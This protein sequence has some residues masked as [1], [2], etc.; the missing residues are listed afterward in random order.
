MSTNDIHIL[1]I[2]WGVEYSVKEAKEKLKTGMSDPRKMGENWSVTIQ[3]CGRPIATY[4]PDKTNDR[5][6]MLCQIMQW[7]ETDSSAFSDILSD[8]VLVDNRVKVDRPLEISSCNFNRKKSKTTSLIGWVVPSISSLHNKN[9]TGTKTYKN[10]R[11]NRQIKSKNKKGI[12]DNKLVKISAHFG[13][14]HDERIEKAAAKQNGCLNIMETEAMHK[15]IQK[16]RFKP[17]KPPRYVTDNVPTSEWEIKREKI[18]DATSYA[19]RHGLYDMEIRKRSE[20][21]ERWQQL[22]T[23]YK[24]Q[25]VNTRYHGGGFFL[26]GPYIGPTLLH[27]GDGRFYNGYYTIE[28][29]DWYSTN[30][31]P[32]KLMKI[33]Y[34]PYRVVTTYFGKEFPHWADFW[35]WYWDETPGPLSLTGLSGR[36]ILNHDPRD[37]DSQG[38]TLS[39]WT[40]A[41][42]R[43]CPTPW[44]TPSISSASSFDEAVSNSV[45]GSSTDV[46]AQ[47][48]VDSS[49][50]EYDECDDDCSSEPLCDDEYDECDDDCSS[51]PLCVDDNLPSMSNKS[52]KWPKSGEESSYDNDDL[53]F[54]SRKRGRINR[55]IIDDDSSDGTEI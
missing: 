29:R 45:C 53:P 50:D 20:Y 37:L 11:G 22:V 55:R 12:L 8:G 49:I 43:W 25:G 48:C 32:I 30:L 54:M 19:L 27:I 7:K 46:E 36:E 34:R 38:D 15:R 4:V 31:E 35:M 41:N 40:W 14:D 18:Q 28:K 42:S 44:D 23:E 51:E 39:D 5:D 9:D 2:T 33:D 13:I 52:S 17:T 24:K 6:R 3:D 47:D 1:R 21:F 10:T 16:R 26:N